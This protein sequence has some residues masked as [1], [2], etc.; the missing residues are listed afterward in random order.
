MMAAIMLAYPV[1]VYF[2]LRHFSVQEVA[3]GIFIL[4]ILRILL[5]RR[6]RNLIPLPA[7]L[8]A[9]LPLLALGIYS[10]SPLYLKFYP[11]SISLSFLAVFAYSVLRP[12]TIVYRIAQLTQPVL[13]E[14][15]TRYTGRVTII[16]CVFFALNAG[17]AA[18]TAVFGSDRQWALYNGLIS[19]L[20]VGTLFAA[21]WAYRT[22]HARQGAA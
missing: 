18:I 9:T 6:Q 15:T 4:L 13:D 21:E 12:P 1:L 20:M 16:W 7:L 5:S 10:G 3:I 17:V 11:V 22:W 8:L 19:Y 2:G 14:Y